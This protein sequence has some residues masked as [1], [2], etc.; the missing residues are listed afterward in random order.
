VKRAVRA[1]AAA[2]AAVLIAAGA[3]QLGGA[4]LAAEIDFKAVSEAAIKK[5]AQAPAGENAASAPADSLSDR[6]ITLDYR[7]RQWV[8]AFRQQSYE[9]HLFSTKVIFVL[10]VLIV[11]FGLFITYLQ[12]SRDYTDASYQAKPVTPTEAPAGD[13]AASPL[14][15]RPSRTV[16]SLKL[17]PGGLE[18]SSQIIGLAVLAFSL[19]FFYLY[20]KNVYP[21]NEEQVSG[22]AEAAQEKSAA[23]QSK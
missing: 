3:A 8:Q 4:A 23:S 2:I 21:I 10:V 14:A 16:T 13:D 12:F 19:G 6:D 11:G 22:K 17:G 20:V 9:W 18:L 1:L 15:A 5:A 7:E